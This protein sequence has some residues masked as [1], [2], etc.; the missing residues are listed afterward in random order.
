[1][2]QFRLD[3]AR[4]PITGGAGGIGLAIAQRFGEAG[5]SGSL[6]STA[7]ASSGPPMICASAAIR[8]TASPPT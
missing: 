6:T 2:N 8:R 7:R 3:Q 4:L 1:M 5:A